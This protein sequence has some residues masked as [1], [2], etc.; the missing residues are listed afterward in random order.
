M[1]AKILEI[2][3]RGRKELVS[4]YLKITR[5]EGTGRPVPIVLG[6]RNWTVSVD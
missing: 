4:E 6:L 2:P 1:Y 5:F 3:H